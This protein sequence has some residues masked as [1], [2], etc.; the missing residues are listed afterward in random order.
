MHMSEHDSFMRIRCCARLNC[1]LSRG[2][3]LHLQKVLCRCRGR[4][5]KEKGRRTALKP[6]SLLRQ[7]TVLKSCVR[8]L[9]PAHSPA[10]IVADVSKPNQLKP[11]STRSEKSQRPALI[12]SPF[13]QLLD[14]LHFHHELVRTR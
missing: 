2:E 6:K 9:L 4:T 12:D 3:W 10:T 13:F 5:S 14:T 7:T 11:C 8:L 1:G